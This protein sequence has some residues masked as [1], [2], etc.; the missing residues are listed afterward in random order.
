MFGPMPVPLEGTFGALEGVVME[1]DD[2]A[3]PLLSGIEIT[4]YLEISFLGFRD[5]VV[6]C[7][8]NWATSPSWWKN[9][10]HDDSSIRNRFTPAA[11]EALAVTLIDF[12]ED[13]PP[14]G[15]SASSLDRQVSSRLEGQPG[16]A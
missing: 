2:C 16:G 14:T 1:L 5:I 10:C 6:Q 7:V 12:L 11:V 4:H 15:C 8:L 9:Y 13:V 3:F